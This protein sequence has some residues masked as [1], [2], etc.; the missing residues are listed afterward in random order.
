[1]LWIFLALMLLAALAMFALPVFLR[2][3]RLP[4]STVVGIAVVTI[5][6]PLI[7]YSLGSPA[8][9]GSREGVASI[10]DMVSSLAA[11]LQD[12]PDDVS[13][14]KMLGRSYFELERYEESADAFGKAVALESANDGQTLADLGQALIMFEPDSINGEAG[15]LFETALS[16]SPTNAKALFYGGMTAINRGDNLLG[17]ER[18]ETLLET[19][20]PPQNVA[21]LLQARISILRGETPPEL[22]PA[23]AESASLLT[24]RVELG[25]R[26]AT[27]VNGGATV[28]L[29]ARDP[30]QPSPPI[31]AV[32]RKAAELPAEITLSDSD[33]MIPGRVPSAFEELEIVAR[34]SVS[35]NPIA[36]S[37]DWF[38]SARVNRGSDGVLQI[39]IDQQVP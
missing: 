25:A 17:A 20:P 15:R 32:R 29:I 16:L 36:Q 21:E 13:G 27:A 26:A 2:E 31:A 30:N 18:W 9:T 34:A 1:M 3:K 6:A 5:T 37:G 4:M 10:D 38:G 33:A 19:S 7:Y 12:E 28:F 8:G 24:V 39:R 14:W 11:R 22:A 35:G 23:V